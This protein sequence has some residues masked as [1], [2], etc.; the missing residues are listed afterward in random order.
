MHVPLPIGFA[1]RGMV[2]EI[3]SPFAPNHLY[4]DHCDQNDGPTSILAS[5]N[6]HLQAQGAGLKSTV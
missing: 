1:M 4:P 2:L 3:S 6:N 5:K